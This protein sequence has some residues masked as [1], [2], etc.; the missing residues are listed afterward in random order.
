MSAKEVK[1]GQDARDLE[2]LLHD[3]YLANSNY[4]WQ[5][6]PFWVSVAVTEIAILDLL[7]QVS[8]K[9]LGERSR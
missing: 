3:V 6:L 4:K 2:K 8:G 7:G 5:G 1:F 9:P